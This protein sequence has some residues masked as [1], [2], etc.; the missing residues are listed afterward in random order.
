MRPGNLTKKGS[1]VRGRPTPAGASD[2]SASV[3]LC[4]G[5]V[6]MHPKSPQRQQHQRDPPCFHRENRHVATGT[7]DGIDEAH[8]VLVKQFV[9]SLTELLRRIIYCDAHPESCQNFFDVDERPGIIFCLTPCTMRV[10]PEDAP[11]GFLFLET[12]MHPWVFSFWRRGLSLS[13]DVGSN[14]RTL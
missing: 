2:V 6:V 12:W 9:Y 11:V 3:R 5:G 14:H 13:G 1:H 10:V 8:H 4:A 7:Y